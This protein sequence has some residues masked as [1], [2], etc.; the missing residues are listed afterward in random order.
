MKIDAKALAKKNAMA[1]HSK[2]PEL[3]DEG[4]VVEADVKSMESHIDSV[5]FF[6]DAVLDKNAPAAH[7]HLSKWMSMY[8]KPMA[9]QDQ[10]Q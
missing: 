2:Q 1:K 6:L 7:G 8:S 4:K 5:R 10:P 9:G 3:R